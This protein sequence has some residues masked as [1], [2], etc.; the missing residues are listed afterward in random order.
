MINNIT[1]RK[2]M[3]FFILGITVVIY[4][5]TLGYIGY[6]LREKAIV[7]AQRLA[8]TFSSQKANEIKS[9]LNEDMA[10]A[11][12]MAAI[13][14]DYTFKPKAQRDSLRKSLMVNI[15]KTYPKYDA[16]W[17]SW[18]LWAIQPGWEK[19]NGRER[20][21][22]Y[23]RDGK[24]NNSS[25]LANLDKDP[26]SGIYYHL[27]NTPSESEKLSEPYWYLDY[28]YSSNRRDSILGISP[29]V[30][31]KVDG[32]FAGV[33]GSD[34]TLDDF[35]SMSEVAFFDKGYAFL[36]SNKGVI[37]AHQNSDFYSHSIDTLSF[38]KS[39]DLDEAKAKI[40]AGEHFS[41]TVY[42]E[43]F[44]EEVY[45]SFAPV[46]IGKSDYPWSAAT[47]VP[48]SEITA[49][50]NATLKITIVVG[51]LGLALLSLVILKISNHITSSIENS[52]HLLKDLALGKLNQNQKLI[53]DSNDELGEMATSVNV[54]V[55]ELVKKAEF[56]KEIGIGNLD[57][58]FEVAGDQDSLGHSLLKMRDNLK[59]VLDDTSSVVEKAGEE[60]DL[61]ARI[62]T[63]GKQG[64][65]KD[66]GESI[67]N[68]LH[69][70][71]IPVIAVNDIVNAMAEGDLTK[72]FTGQVTGDM[73]KLSHNL[74]KA[75]DNLKELLS[76]IA[77]YANVIDESS[78]EMNVV[79]EEMNT[80]TK[81]IASAISEM[82]NGAQTQ[83]S[84]VDESS[85]LVEGILKSSNE[86]GERAET[87]NEAAK[88]GVNSSEKG[89][90]MVNKVVFNMEDISE[91][92]SKT[93]TSI[94][95]LMERSTEITRVLGVITE[96]ASQTNL[97]ALNAAIEAAQA[98]DAGRGF[99]VVAEEIRKLAEDSR[100]SAKEIEKLIN[101]VQTDTKEAA[102]VIEIMGT[103]VK[104][105]DQASKEA[106]EVFKEIADTSEKTFSHSQEILQATKLQVKDINAVVAITENV[107]V[108]AEET[109]AG[110][111]QV[112]S[113]ATELS[114][115]MMGYTE[116][117]QKLADVAAQLK[118]GLK[119][120]ILSKS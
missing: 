57:S 60:G 88:L 2:K 104:N 40:A 28:D 80:N 106:S 68:L 81:E 107:V 78:A 77:D 101:D 44:G 91:Y 22:F 117:S 13:V 7:E 18:Q 76:D 62:K 94:N 32:R 26:D 55:D 53:V 67:N 12:D 50:F 25:E 63:E 10:V 38:T 27:K 9:I 99:A 90:D 3:M 46:N 23:M 17:M 84:K 49:P 39:I 120:F 61:S 73:E 59:E 56:S 11:R 8:D 47:I 66:L 48:V 52:N 43:T 45:I 86:M 5:I 71:S 29:T 79:S 1:V 69:S 75:L 51:L 21:N 16:V 20:V 102:S 19:E 100:N 6:S 109:A 87:I 119:K 37:I 115:G 111:E 105:G 93:Q 92:S 70:I 33:I 36:L 96:I 103:S 41:Y 24:V 35:Q 72:R 54:L 82:S 95:V 108:I 30:T 74:N 116:K 42:D 4:L 64:G 98:G 31:I 15:L 14:K 83:V 118:Q 34:M 112:A 65:W 113:S 85:N 110:T 114:S 97:L 58:K 89:L